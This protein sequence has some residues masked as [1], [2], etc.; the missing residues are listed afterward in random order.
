MRFRSLPTK[1]Q[2]CSYKLIDSPFLTAHFKPLTYIG[3]P[4]LQATHTFEQ[5][6][7]R[8][9]SNLQG[10]RYLAANI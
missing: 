2:K 1:S 4:F 5:G 8:P 7:D 9:S 6:A 3:P 10:V